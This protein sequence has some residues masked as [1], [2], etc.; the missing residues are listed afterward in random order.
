[1]LNLFVTGIFAFP[2]FVFPTGQLLP[3][4]YY[5][6][7]NPQMLNRV[8]NL[9]GVEYFRKLLLLVFWGREKNRKKYSNGSRT[10][11]RHFDYQ[12][13]QSEF[14]HLGALVVIFALSFVVL[15][16]GHRESFIYIHLFNIV[17]N[18]Y[19]VVLQR[20]HRSAIQ[21]LLPRR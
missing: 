12:T 8:Y 17:G 4:A 20:K 5:Q 16:Q 2:G 6:V 13:R 10:G 21:R 19:P 18:F 3:A 9:L 15:A 11:L 14:G 1:V 7:R